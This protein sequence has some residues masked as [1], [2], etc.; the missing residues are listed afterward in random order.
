MQL[1]DNR[2]SLMHAVT[3][4]I[5]HAVLLSA[6]FFK[7]GFLEKKFFR[8]TIRMSNRL[9][10]DQARQNVWVQT[11]CKGYQQMTLGSRVKACC[12]LG[13]VILS[14]GNI[15]CSDQGLQ[16]RLLKLFII[17]LVSELNPG[18]CC[19]YLKESSE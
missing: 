13:N 4:E 9:G 5:F 3:W 16:T 10:P 1:V 18:I 14:F 12:N 6:D 11:V 2:L 8:N 17:V 19:G 15:L 7:I